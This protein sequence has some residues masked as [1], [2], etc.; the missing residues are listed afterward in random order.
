MGML[1]TTEK[2]K[3]KNYSEVLDEGLTNMYSTNKR[4]RF[5]MPRQTESNFNMKGRR[6]T[7]SGSQKRR[8][9]SATN[10]QTN[11]LS[12]SLQ[13]TAINEKKDRQASNYN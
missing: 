13:L 8:R 4:A 12:Q 10:R 6:T 5:S 9:T 7:K 2:R 11:A 3:T 1:Q